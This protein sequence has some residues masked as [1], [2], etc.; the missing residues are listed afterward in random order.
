VNYAPT[1]AD[2]VFAAFDGG[3][4]VLLTP[5]ATNA[6][7][8]TPIP[9]GSVQVSVRVERVGFW[10]FTQGLVIVPGDPPA[11]TWAGE[12][13][14]QSR[15][16]DVWSRSGGYSLCYNAVLMQCRDA[17]AKVEQ[18]VAED[19][20]TA[21]YLDPQAHSV[22]DFDLA[23]MLSHTGLGWHTFNH[24]TSQTL[25]DGNVY[26]VEMPAIPKLVG[27]YVPRIVLDDLASGG[28]VPGAVPLHFHVFFHP[29]PWFFKGDY[30]FSRDY[31][32][33][34][35]RYM[36]AYPAL[37]NGHGLV[38]Q[39]HATGKRWILVFPIGSKLGWLGTLGLQNNLYRFV[40]ELAHWLQRFIG[41]GYAIQKPGKVGVSAFSA[42][43]HYVVAALATQNAEFEDHHLT[44]VYAFDP[45]LPNTASACARMRS[46]LRANEA[47]RRLRVYTLDGN[48]RNLLRNAGT[49]MVAM[50]GP[51]GSEEHHGSAASVLFVPYPTIWPKM[52]S[53]V[54]PNFPPPPNVPTQ[55]DVPDDYWGVHDVSSTLFLEQAMKG[56][57]L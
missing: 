32:N 14:L 33:L 38:N 31:V 19:D 6:Y 34:F 7:W 9:D 13:V 28:K 25:P 46:W 45:V 26:F 30:P 36:L 42:A 27:F 22:R 51:R 24:T 12:R 4:D 47:E 37:Y 53:E 56:S 5:D 44:E 17:R 20:T 41:M 11:L 35:W 39:L 15:N 18:V 1:A 8:E 10:T 29:S 16:T 40:Q 2:R 48:W 50:P 57:N 21:R 3:P 55:N 49:N 43:A 54:P 52:D 23:P